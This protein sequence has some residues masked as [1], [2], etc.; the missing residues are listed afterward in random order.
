[1]GYFSNGTEGEMY[2]EKYCERCVHD[3]HG[4]NNCPVWSLHL[5]HNYDQNENETLKALLDELIPREG[6]CN[7][8]CRMFIPLPQVKRWRA[9]L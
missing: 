3:G 2:R 9:T 1:M 4:E 8:Q 7:Q 5:L 6:I